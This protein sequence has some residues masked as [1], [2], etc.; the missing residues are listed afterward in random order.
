MIY[1]V[2]IKENLS[3]QIVGFKQNGFPRV[4]DKVWNFVFG[5][6]DP[7]LTWLL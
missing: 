2:V 5:E 4:E 7:I 3:S 6:V 1:N